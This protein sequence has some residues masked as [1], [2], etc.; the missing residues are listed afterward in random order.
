MG[1]EM[2]FFYTSH[3]TWEGGKR[4]VLSNDKVPRLTVATPPEFRGP[5]GLWSPEQLFVA[6]ANACVMTTLLAI[7]EKS[8]LT[9]RS[10]SSTA[11]G[12]LEKVEAEE[13][14]IHEE[15]GL[16]ITEIVIRPRL[17]VANEGDLGKAEKVLAKAEEQCLIS[18]SLKCQV[19]VKPEILVAPK[20]ANA[21]EMAVRV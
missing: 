21:V 11:T 17:T 6:A 16:Q 7:A 14:G 12:K 9:I 15:G 4:G 19:T 2:L 18:R 3:L 20:A 1:K 10:Y 8:R 5:E 13:M